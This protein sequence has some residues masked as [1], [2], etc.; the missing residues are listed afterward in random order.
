MCSVGSADETG[1]EVE[2]LGDVVDEVEGVAAE[3]AADEDEG[4][5]P[6]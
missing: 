1:D 2:E 5:V 3:A 6:G 4:M